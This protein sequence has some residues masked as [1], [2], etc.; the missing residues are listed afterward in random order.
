[1]D[2]RPN[3]HI[4]SEGNL[5]IVSPGPA[6]KPANKPN[7]IQRA[8]TTIGTNILDGLVGDVSNELNSI[9]TLI[10]TFVF[11][12]IKDKVVRT[13]NFKI[14][15]DHYDN[16]MEEAFYAIL[17]KYNNLKRQ[18]N[19]ELVTYRGS[20]DISVWYRLDD[21]YHQLNYRNFKIMVFINTKTSASAMSGRSSVSR[22]YSI[23]TF[24][25]GESF[26]NQF[27]H[28]MLVHRNNLLRVKA[29]LHT[30]NVYKDG[31]EGDGYTYW[32]RA[33]SISKRKLRTVYLDRE[34]KTK[35]VDTINRFFSEKQWYRERGIAHNLKI[36]LYGQVGTGKDTIAKMIASEWC[37]NIYYI[38]GGKTGRFVPNAI[39][40]SYVNN[41]LFLI[42]DI[43]RYPFLINDEL[44]ATGALTEDKVE[45]NKLTFAHMINALD[46]VMSG[47]DRIIIMTT[48]HIEK[49]SPTFLRPGRIDLMLEIKR[50]GPEVFRRFVWDFYKKALPENLKLA[51]DD[52]SV[53]EMQADSFL[54][55][56]PLEE[57]LDKYLFNAKRD[58]KNGK[59]S[60]SVTD[61]LVKIESV[62]NPK[63]KKG[64][65]KPAPK[66]DDDDDD[67]DDVGGGR[68]E[69]LDIGE[70]IDDLVSNPDIKLVAK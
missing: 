42:S 16:W 7:I 52:I 41:P 64:K 50:V 44:P 53:P 5:S 1:L 54:L 37:R 2:K 43:D 69:E 66:K 59:K 68:G 56:M 3:A 51:R 40:S 9:T 21:G 24:N 28:D 19:L 35:I 33:P 70:F 17:Y 10:G 32:D 57:F 23:A 65:A 15:L 26:V 13:I 67:D 12:R 61:D 11:K 4:D 31:H 14:G 47:E 58:G 55:K 36:L 6:P 62:L 38:T 39:T 20:N 8:G 25:L 63:G 48:N 60:E 27:E 45:E 29:D 34:T 18:S 46:G 30:I 22:E 49:F